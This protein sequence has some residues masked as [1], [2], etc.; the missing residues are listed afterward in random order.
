MNDLP[1]VTDRYEKGSTFVLHQAG[2]RKEFCI[3]ITSDY[4]P[5]YADCSDG[6]IT[7]IKCRKNA[8]VFSLGD[9]SLWFRLCGCIF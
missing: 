3:M 8:L 2:K 6:Y 5:I 1:E 7:T 4:C 9:A